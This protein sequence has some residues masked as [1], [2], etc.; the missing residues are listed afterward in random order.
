MISGV[1]AILTGETFI[2]NT[3]VM[4]MLTLIFFLVNTLYFIFI[5][6][7]DLHKR[8]GEPYLHYKMEVHRWI[9]R[10]TPYQPSKS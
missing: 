2:L 7:P 4:L 6:E 8:F 9:P 1:L 10:I 3:F 5:E